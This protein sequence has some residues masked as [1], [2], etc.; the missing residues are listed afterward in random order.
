MNIKKSFLA[1]LVL[2]NFIFTFSFADV[3]FD[4]LTRFSKDSARIFWEFLKAPIETSAIT[5][6]S[7]WAVDA[8]IKD[9]EPG[10][11]LEIGAG[12]GTVTFELVKKLEGLGKGYHLDVVEQNEKMFC[13][14]C[15]NLLALNQE[16]AFK[17]GSVSLY[18]CFFGGSECPFDV[19]KYADLYDTI[20]STIPIT[21]LPKESIEQILNK[22]RV[23]LK[24]NGK[25]IYISLWGAKKTRT[26]YKRLESKI[27]K[28]PEIYEKYK[29]QVRFTEEFTNKH[30]DQSEIL[31]NLNFTPM[32]IYFATKKG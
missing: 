19:R 6:S 15:N 27:K 28:K 10:N 14:L 13:K 5:A 3:D 21:R 7:P 2:S 17:Q 32:R 22:I 16:Q 26:W 4:R 9:V 20:I 25:F 1:G 8:M 30:F 12:P 31:V 18:N 11:I 24:P 29:E 23:L